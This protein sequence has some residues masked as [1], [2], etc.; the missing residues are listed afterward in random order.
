[1][2]LLLITILKLVSRLPLRALYAISDGAY[3]ILYYVIRYRRDIVMRNLKEAFPE[4]DQKSLRRIEKDYYHYLCDLIVETLKLL[5]I[6]DSELKRRVT[7]EGYEMI[8]RSTTEGKSCVLLLGHYGNWEWVQEIS[9]YFDG[10]AAHFSIYHPLKSKLWDDI[11]KQIRGRWGVPLLPQTSAAKVLLN[12]ENLPW[13]CGFIADH[14][15][16]T[17]SEEAKTPFLNHF[18]S[19]IYGPE[20]IGNKIGA[21]FYYLSMERERRGTYKICFHKLTPKE[22]KGAYPYTKEF[23][24]Y[25]ENSIKRKPAYWMWSHKRWKYDTMLSEQPT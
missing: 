4:K 14:R 9:R 20:A 8:N 1:M 23:W 7:V 6:S 12:K 15:P 10:E 17:I 11:F 18:T 24:S 21:D 16:R 5:T 25:L 22:D 13:I 2:K 3:Y 19:F